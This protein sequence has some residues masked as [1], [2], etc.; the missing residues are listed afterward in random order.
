MQK[1]VATSD[2]FKTYE[3]SYFQSFMRPNSQADLKSHDFN[4]LPFF[5]HEN[6]QCAFWLITLQI[7]GLEMGFA[8]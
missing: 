2:E 1:K 5:A 3:Y 7:Y 6:L 8:F 4:F